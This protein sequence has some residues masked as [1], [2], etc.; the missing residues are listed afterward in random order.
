MYFIHLLGLQTPPNFTLWVVFLFLMLFCITFCGNLLI[1]TLVSYSKALRS[2]MYFFLSHLSFSDI[3]LT[4]DILPVMI[5][6]VLKKETKILFSDCILQFYLFGIVEAFECLLLCVMS[7]DRYLAICKP[8][9]YTLIMTLKLCWLLV[10]T[11]W[12]SGNLVLLIHIITI[13]T[14]HFCGPGIIDNFFCDLDPILGL[15]CTDTT[16]VHLEILSLGIFVVVI[17]FFIIII[18]YVYVIFTIFN[19]PSIIGRQKVFSTCSSHLTVVF[20]YYGSIGCVYMVP[21]NGQSWNVTKFLSLLYTVGTP[22]LN[23]IIYSLRNEDLKTAFGK[24][25]NDFLKLSFNKR[26]HV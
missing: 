23:P 24:V 8:L 16:F 21:K 1:I 7:Y 3:L 20:I 17:P 6:G 11:C 14:L 26:K 22:L 2:P 9:H 18:S 5:H 4:T 12:I 10:I 15:V 13:S 25:I 19:I